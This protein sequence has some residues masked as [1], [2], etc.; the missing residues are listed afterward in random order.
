MKQELAKIAPN[1]TDLEQ[2]V[3]GCMLMEKRAC[4][5]GL[6]MLEAAHF[7]AKENELVFAAIKALHDRGMGVDLLTVTQE[8]K[9]RSQLESVGGPVY[10]TVLTGRV[11]GT[12]N[13][14][15]YARIIQEKYIQRQLIEMGSDLKRIND[16][17]D[18]FEAID[19]I[20]ERMSSLNMLSSDTDPET[21]SSVADGMIENREPPL[22]ICP[23]M[24][25][26]DRHFAMGPG[27]VVVIG[28]RPAIGKTTLIVNMA[29]NFARQGYKTIIVSLEMSKQQLVSKMMSSL[30][31]ID[32]E[33]ITRNEIN[34]DERSRIANAAVYAG[35]WLPRVM[36][37]DRAS[38]G[39][40]QI[41]GL[42]QRAVRRH[43]CH[44]AIIDYLQLI[45]GEGD[46]S[47]E[48][49]TNISKSCKKA[50]RSS[51]IRLIE[52]SQLKRR[53]GA[54]VN[55]QMS[56]LRE[57]GQI[58]ADGDVILLLGREPLSQMLNINVAKNKIGPIG[59]IQLPFN[60]ITQRIGNNLYQ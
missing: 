3:L 54:E 23:D 44:V 53:D 5:Q 46:G 20:N 29:M 36:I 31:G 17:D 6:E 32:S 27:N 14:V 59:I 43:G 39:V 22:F 12:V 41:H 24:G 26:L 16:G 38:L 30:T 18:V 9:N 15:Y 57:S 37:D 4:D 34:E 49:M 7:Y 28:A 56:D 52:L 58:E 33:R 11:S 21:A 47:Y 13:V 25:D 19:K 2:A 51:G 60:L 35:S 45:D 50:A 40:G 42:L 8:L 10:L 55:P 48:S 1:A